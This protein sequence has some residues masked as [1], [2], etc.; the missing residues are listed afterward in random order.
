MRI[1]I[2]LITFCL[3]AFCENLESNSSSQERFEVQKTKSW[4]EHLLKGKK[5]PL[6]EYAAFYFGTD[7]PDKVYMQSV[8]DVA[9]NYAYDEFKGIDSSKF[10][11]FWAGDF[12]FEK[13]TLKRLVFD[14]SDKDLRIFIDGN[15]IF[16][17][18]ENMSKKDLTYNFT[19][20]NHTIE[21]EMMNH[22]HTVDFYFAL[23]DIVEYFSQNDIAEKINKKWKNFEIFSVSV[24][25]SSGF[26]RK[27]VLNLDQKY[28][29]P[30]LLLLSSYNSADFQ[31][32]NPYDNKLAFVVFNKDSRVSYDKK[33]GEIF[34]LD[35]ERLPFS[36]KAEDC[37]CIPRIG[38]HCSENSDIININEKIKK[39][40]GVGLS[41]ISHKYSAASFKI[42]EKIYNQDLIDEVMD[43]RQKMEKLK[44]DCQKEQSSNFNDVF[45]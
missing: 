45:K 34:Y 2:I 30:V 15:I 3:S 33:D 19:K 14:N 22:W 12:E 32:L 16:D 35:D 24:Y 9:V 40:Y 26:D 13:D 21:I 41:G 11:A 18:T 37:Y 4:G 27:I 20:G 38:L 6:N 39:I 7:S 43:A 36:Y 1:L 17:S 10:A 31:I 44:I 8:K 25:E 28:K 29:K 5:P 42:P 23:R